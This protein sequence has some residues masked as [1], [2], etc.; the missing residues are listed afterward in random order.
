MRMGFKKTQ[1]GLDG[2]APGGY[3]QRVRKIAKAPLVSYP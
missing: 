1:L 3:F 2:N